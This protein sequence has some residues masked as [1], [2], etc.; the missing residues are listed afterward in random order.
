M[1]AVRSVGRAEIGEEKNTTEKRVRRGLTEM[2]ISMY[3]YETV[4]CVFVR[5]KRELEFGTDDALRAISNFLGKVDR[6]VLWS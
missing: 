6:K 5:M 4:K 2:C 1:A 3:W